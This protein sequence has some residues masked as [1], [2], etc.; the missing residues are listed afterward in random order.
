[1]TVLPGSATPAGLVAWLA[2]GTVAISLAAG[3]LQAGQAYLRAGAGGRMNYDLGGQLFDHLQRLSPRF[4]HRHPAGDLLRRITTDS[5]CLRDFVL[6]VFFSAAISLVSIVVFFVVMWQLDPRLSLIALL[7]VLPLALAMKRFLGPMTERIYD[8][9][10]LEGEMLA[11]AERTLS[12]LPVV[13]AFTSEDREDARF[14]NLTGRA[15][16]A[17][18]RALAAQLHF[19]ASVNTATAAG[20]AAIMIVGGFHVLQ[21]SLSIG[22][23]IVFLA[24]LPALY[25]PLSDLAQ[26]SSGWASVAAGARRVREVLNDADFVPQAPCAIPL[27]DRPAAERGQVR[28]DQVVF[29]YDP[30]RPVLHGITLEVRA[31]EVLALVGRTGA[32]KSTLVSLIPRLFDPWEGRVLL[33]GT[34]LRDAPLAS[35]RSRVAIVLQDSCL[36]PLSVAENIAYGRPGAQGRKSL[37]PRWR[38]TPI[39]S[40]ASSRKVTTLSSASAAPPCPAESGS[41]W[42]SPEHYSKTRRC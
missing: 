26:L 28:F 18:F 34:D 3:T 11:Q 10:Q 19:T 6:G 25:A 41:A 5:R 20:T 14:R 13:Q 16:S 2:L 30:A 21:G 29:G 9:Q 7:V 38:P 22:G 12:A 24:Y 1:M 37:P 32:G 15:L 36:L 35:L 4:H 40:S 33:D 42:P 8:Q 17:Y 27:P 31:G 23:L 39:L